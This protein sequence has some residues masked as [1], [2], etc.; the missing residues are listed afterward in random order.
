MDLTGARW[1]IAELQGRL[2]TTRRRVVVRHARVRKPKKLLTTL[3]VTNNYD[4]WDASG[5]TSAASTTLTGLCGS[6]EIAARIGAGRRALLRRAK[7]GMG[8]ARG[9]VG[10]ADDLALVVHRRSL[11]VVAAEGT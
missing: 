4:Y 5:N 8:A 2:T 3:R 11:T 1:V 9:G 6:A 10:R 7:R